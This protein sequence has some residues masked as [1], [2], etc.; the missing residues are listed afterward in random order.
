MP[1]CWEK[2]AILWQL[3]IQPEKGFP[4]KTGGSMPTYVYIVLLGVFLFGAWRIMD[5]IETFRVA[6]RPPEPAVRAPRF[7]VTAWACLV[8]GAVVAFW[9][10]HGLIGI[11]VL[12]L[13]VMLPVTKEKRHRRESRIGQTRSLPPLPHRRRPVRLM[14][15]GGFQ[16]QPASNPTNSR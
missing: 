5:S 14:A 4:V 1:R 2:P 7:Q 13:E 3:S 11:V 8:L 15:N 10:G 6:R 12:V 16:S 9:T